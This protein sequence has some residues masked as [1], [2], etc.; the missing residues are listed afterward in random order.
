MD[1]IH[2]LVLDQ[3]FVR[4]MNDKERWAEFSF[5]AVIENFLGNKKSNNY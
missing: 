2:A 1:Q 5:V 3:D 4:K